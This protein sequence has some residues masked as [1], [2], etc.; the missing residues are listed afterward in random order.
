ML[1]GACFIK[2]RNQPVLILSNCPY[3]FEFE[4]IKVREAIFETLP[5]E[6]VA[7]N[8]N[9]Y[10]PFAQAVV[11]K[12]HCKAVEEFSMQPSASILKLLLL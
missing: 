10:E 3:G 12:L 2:T 9:E 5:F 6:S 11:S 4:T 7:F 8:V 1:A